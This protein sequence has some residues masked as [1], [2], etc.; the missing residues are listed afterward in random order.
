M[1]GRR[2]VS[3]VVLAAALPASAG[4]VERRFVVTTNVPGAQVY[5][6]NVAI[7][8]SPADSRWDYPGRYELRAVAQGY[9]P[10]RVYKQ[11]NPKWYEYP[12][13]DFIFEA[14]WP[15]HI[16]DVRRFELELVPATQ[17]RTD[18]LL[19]AAN[20]LRERGRNLPAPEQPDPPRA[21]PPP[22]QPPPAVIQDL[23]PTGP[24][25][26]PVGTVVP[27]RPAGTQ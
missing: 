3:W 25:P 18:E 26:P 1:A 20:R 2:L 17:V 16:E 9:E 27:S 22:P 24:A 23:P 6:N 19:D 13:L 7:G 12:G 11:V 21:A 14:L 8:P 10:L 4:C 5:V 15:F